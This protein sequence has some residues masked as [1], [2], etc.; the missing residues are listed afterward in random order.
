MDEKLATISHC[1]CVFVYRVSNITEH[2][3]RYWQSINAKFIYISRNPRFHS[4]NNNMRWNK[5]WNRILCC[6]KPIGNSATF[7]NFRLL[8]KAPKGC[9]YLQELRFNPQCNGSVTTGKINS[10]MP[11]VIAY[12]LRHLKCLRICDID[13]LADGLQ[14]MQ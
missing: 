1:H 5:W 7:V 11:R 2:K 8:S 14:V 4:Y 3:K 12:I 6:P 13:T 10:V 9:K